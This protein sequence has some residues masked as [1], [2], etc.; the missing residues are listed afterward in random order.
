MVHFLTWPNNQ[1]DFLKFAFNPLSK[2]S[3]FVHPMH[4]ES[5]YHYALSF[6]PGPFLQ[7]Q[8]TA[9]LHLISIFYR[10]VI[11]IESWIFVIL[12]WCY[13]IY[14]WHWKNN[15]RHSCNQ[16]CSLIGVKWLFNCARHFTLF[17]LHVIK[18]IRSSS[19]VLADPTTTILLTYCRHR[20]A[21]PLVTL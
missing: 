10:H 16:A 12:L 5:V 21:L 20:K 11:R 6:E 2:R 13:A 9:S 7:E 19:I 17:W 18:I 4:N 8:L 14:S 15:P 3:L 1:G